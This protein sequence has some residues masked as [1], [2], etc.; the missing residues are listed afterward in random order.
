MSLDLERVLKEEA[1]G[2][3]DGWRFV[4]TSGVG[5]VW[6]KSVSD[7]PVHLV[8]VIHLKNLVYVI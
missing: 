4:K 1:S 3:A 5:E 8:K 7:S 6:K 2:E